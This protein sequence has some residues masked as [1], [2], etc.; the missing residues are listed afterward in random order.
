VIY[1]EPPLD[2]DGPASSNF[3]N[4]GFGT[5][6][7][8]SFANTKYSAHAGRKLLQKQEELMIS[9]ESGPVR[10]DWSLLRISSA[11]K[12]PRSLAHTVC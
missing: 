3:Q 7:T 12:F 8:N 10:A 9:S 2:S 5:S 1:P 11:N 4:N 6:S